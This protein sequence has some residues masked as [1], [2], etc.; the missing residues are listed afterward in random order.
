MV[1]SPL[2]PV[3]AER[4]LL[5]PPSASFPYDFHAPDYLSFIC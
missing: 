3:G 5:T 4:D 1:F 2:Y